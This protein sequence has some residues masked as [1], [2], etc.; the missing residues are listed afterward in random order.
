M[1]FSTFSANPACVPESDRRAVTAESF[2]AADRGELHVVVHEVLPLKQAVLAH[3][4]MEAG[5]I[6]GR[7]VLTP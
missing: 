7:I 1:T 4:K 2:A 3:Q 5:Q 6:L